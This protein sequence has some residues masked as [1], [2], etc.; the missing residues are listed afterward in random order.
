MLLKSDRVTLKT[1]D[2]IGGPWYSLQ[3][4]EIAYHLCRKLSFNKHLQSLTIAAMQ[5]SQNLSYAAPLS[6]ATS[7]IIPGPMVVDKKAFLK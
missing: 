1:T 5:L 3:I 7:I 6:D 2:R 4:A